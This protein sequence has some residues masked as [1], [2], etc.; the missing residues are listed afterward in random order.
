ME[1][2]YDT[3]TIH[4]GTKP[5]YNSSRLFME[6]ISLHRKI[7]GGSCEEKGISS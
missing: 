7:E 6:K 1:I 3:A 2:A 5:I 4:T